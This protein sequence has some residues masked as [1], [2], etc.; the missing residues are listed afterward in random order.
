DKTVRVW[1]V[2][3][4]AELRIFKGHTDWVRSV[5]FSGNGTRVAS[6]SDDNT[7]CVW[8]VTSSAQPQVFQGHTDTVWSVSFSGDG[9][10]I[11]SGSGGYGG[12]NTVRVWDVQSGAQ[13]RV[14]KG[15]TGSVYSV[16]FSDDGTR[17]ASGSDDKTVR[18]LELDLKM[19][20]KP[21]VR[22][23]AGRPAL[24][25]TDADFR[26]ATGLTVDQLRLIKQRGGI[27]DSKDD[28]DNDDVDDEKEK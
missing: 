8:D 11:A 5:S 15:H 13:L 21:R 7:V 24:S 28:H 1:D 25:L 20:V 12:D 23:I 19:Q 9:T 26:G 6:G 14:F 16:G 22:W 17:I 2:Q 18:L 4:G 10:R 27:T 3:S